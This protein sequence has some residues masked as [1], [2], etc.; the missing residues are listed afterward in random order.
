M[1][2][3]RPTSICFVPEHK[4]TR[5][6]SESSW[7]PICINTSW[8]IRFSNKY[9]ILG[10]VQSFACSVAEKTRIFLSQIHQHLQIDS[11]TIPLTG[12]LYSEAKTTSGTHQCVSPYHVFD[13]NVT[14]TSGSTVGTISWDDIVAFATIATS[15]TL[16]TSSSVVRRKK[17]VQNVTILSTETIWYEIK[18]F[19][20]L[21]KM[22]KVSVE[23]RAASET[24]FTHPCH[25]GG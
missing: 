5:V 19:W 25:N 1:R 3:D 6:S 20:R 13:R 18:Q 24:N 9:H 21:I 22:E 7:N 10:Q 14:T 15:L 4:R 2:G 11:S 23:T 17:H 8:V 12:V 16:L